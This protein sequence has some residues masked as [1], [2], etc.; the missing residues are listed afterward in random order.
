MWGL[1]SLTCRVWGLGL[2]FFGLSSFEGLFDI[3]MIFAWYLDDT[4]MIFAWYLYGI[5]VIFA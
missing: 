5:C 3:W 2:D 4:C 1:V